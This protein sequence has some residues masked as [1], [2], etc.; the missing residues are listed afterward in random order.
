M[1]HYHIQTHGKCNEIPYQCDVGDCNSVFISTKSLYNH[2]RRYHSS[3]HGSFKCKQC[4]KTFKTYKCLKYHVSNGCKLRVI[5]RKNKSVNTID[6]HDL[7]SIQSESDITSDNDDSSSSGGS[8]VLSSSMESVSP[9]EIET[10][11]DISSD[12][13]IDA[14]SID[15]ID[16]NVQIDGDINSESESDDIGD[17]NCGENTRKNNK[18]PRISL[19]NPK[20]CPVSGCPTVCHNPTQYSKHLQIHGK[21]DEIPFQCD[22]ANCFKV[23]TNTS[24][25]SN[26]KRAHMKYGSTVTIEGKFACPNCLK[27]FVTL[28]ALGNHKRY[29]KN[30][31]KLCI[32]KSPTKEKYKKTKRVKRKQYGNNKTKLSSIANKKLSKYQCPNCSSI[33]CGKLGLVNHLI[34][35]H[36][37]EQKI[38]NSIARNVIRSM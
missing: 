27:Q 3:I 21:C 32:T 6:D 4:K 35:I 17:S 23:F 1:F 38:A 5:G 12:H 18:P 30:N 7:P 26:H 8:D 15:I 10:D 16:N 20:K 22:I 11:H 33:L 36:R 2:K 19:S 31:S 9:S 24:S 28:Q 25:L 29:A 14:H 37:V 13:E 34:N